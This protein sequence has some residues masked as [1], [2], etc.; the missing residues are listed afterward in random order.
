MSDG[1]YYAIYL[2]LVLLFGLLILAL[3]MWASSDT[4]SVTECAL[5][6]NSSVVNNYGSF[7]VVPA[8]SPNF[9]L[10]PT[11]PGVL[12]LYPISNQRFLRPSTYEAPAAFDSIIAVNPSGTYAVTVTPSATTLTVNTLRVANNQIA[13]VS[14]LVFTTTALTV[15]SANF[16]SDTRLWLLSDNGSV[17]QLRLVNAAPEAV[18]QM[19]SVTNLA[20]Y[21]SMIANS[22]IMYVSTTT[23]IEVYTPSPT[24]GLWSLSTT[25]AAPSAPFVHGT[26]SVTTPDTKLGAR[27]AAVGTTILYASTDS[28]VDISGVTYTDPGA[29]LQYKGGAWT[30]VVVSPNPVDDGGFG[31]DFTLAQGI[32]A[33][34]LSLVVGAKAV[35]TAL[36]RNVFAYDDKLVLTHA[37]GIHSNN[38]QLT[39]S[40]T[41]SGSALLSGDS[42]QMVLLSFNC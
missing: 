7:A 10:V 28:D 15:R 24:D 5:F 20:S 23:G 17:G 21:S 8:D 38:V 35:N 6:I 11:A 29:V 30:G 16:I 18:V 1:G 31:T 22:Q 3:V 9:A 25:I 39:G 14:D 4:P 40:T 13:F 27:M 2:F 37:L 36:E 19:I 42:L 41:S 12:A 32:N 34:Q 33:S 26:I